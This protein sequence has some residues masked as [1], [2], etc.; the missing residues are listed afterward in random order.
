M[1]EA[2]K[3]AIAVTVTYVGL[4]VVAGGSWVAWEFGGAAAEITYLIGLCL[5]G[6]ITY[7]VRLW[8]D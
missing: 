5:L 2:L 4:V 6:W 3:W 8:I 1:T 7:G